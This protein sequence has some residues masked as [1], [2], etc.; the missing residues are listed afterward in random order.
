MR[1][2]LLLLPVLLLGEMLK[3]GDTIAP[4]TIED[5][6]GKT[7]IAGH[8]KVW[9]VTWDKATTR[10]ANLFFDHHPELLNQ[11]TTAMIA[12]FS[13]IPSGILNMFVLPWMRHFAH[14]ILLSYDEPF[15]AMLPYRSG[16]V[17]VLV[18]DEGTI[19]KIEY[20]ED[21]AGL[22]KLLLRP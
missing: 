15:N 21:E 11:N 19:K 7:H 6:H 1:L 9:V 18:L 5:Q 22:E 20:A 3:I 10:T 2:L 8:E 14:P 4:R 13:T 12:D 17:T 16:N